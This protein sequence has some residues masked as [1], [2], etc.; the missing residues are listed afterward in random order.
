MKHLNLYFFGCII[1]GIF[2]ISGCQSQQFNTPASEEQ[3]VTIDAQPTEDDEPVIEEK[4]QIVLEDESQT[5]EAAVNET[6]PIDEATANERYK[7]DSDM[8]QYPQGKFE[9]KDGTT[10]TAAYMNYLEG[11]T[12]YYASAVFEKGK[13]VKVQ[14][15]LKENV[16][17]D[18]VLAE[19]GLPAEV[20]YDE[21]SFN[22]V[23]DIIVN[24]RFA[25]ENIQRLPSEWE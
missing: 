22:N 12:F 13:L 14:L 19:W 20:R 6:T 1:A 10:V 11:E 24:E 7:L 16:S 3:T 17:K 21:S 8:D 15:E 2:V 23:V 4:P 9:F 5:E 25:D 18:D